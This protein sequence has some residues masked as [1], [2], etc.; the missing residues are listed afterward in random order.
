MTNEQ[1]HIERIQHNGH[2]V[3]ST[4][5]R[6]ALFKREYIGYSKREAVRLFRKEAA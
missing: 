5:I 2:L 1:I 3:L 6:G 4:R